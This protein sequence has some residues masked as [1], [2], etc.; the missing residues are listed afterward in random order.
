[1]PDLLTSLLPPGVVVEQT[2][3]LIDQPVAP[4]EEAAVATAV[5]VRR[6]ELRTGR[7]L[8]RRAIGRLGLPGLAA[9]V[10]PV[11]PGRE[12][13]W[14]SGVVGS[15][16]HCPGFCAAAVARGEQL[17]ALGID[18][19]PAQPLPPEVRAVVA[20]PDELAAVDELGVPDRL[21]FCLKE[22]VF[23]AWY[24]A[25]GAWLDFLDVRV[26]V[27]ADGRFAVVPVADH[28]GAGGAWLA[29]LVGTWCATPSWLAA[30][31]TAH[32]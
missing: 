19:E 21:L 26:E 28:L 24:P 7:V 11:G 6:A 31:V 3:E 2:G 1:M 12:P 25:T 32:V 13:V 15:I 4:A 10:I 23:K 22:A 17:A 20:T 5:P 9:A 30:T 27:G 29:G 18:V 16:T 8:A 14:P